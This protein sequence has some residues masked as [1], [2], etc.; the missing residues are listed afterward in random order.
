MS[1]EL[2][3]FQTQL[4]TELKGHVRSR[5]EDH[6]DERAYRPRRRLAVAASIAVVAAGAIGAATLVTS[7]AQPAFAVTSGPHDTIDVKINRMENADLLEQALRDHGVQTIVDYRNDGTLCADNRYEFAPS[8]SD[9]RTVFVM[10][11]GI[12]ITLDRRDVPPGTTVVV[13]ATRVPDTHGD[14]EQRDVKAFNLGIAQGPVGPCVPAA[15]EMP[16]P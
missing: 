6:Q 15:V 7:T 4:L 3:S 13:T 14:H 5:A 12:D 9:S 2:D 16:V 10:G 8:A 1:R 11:E